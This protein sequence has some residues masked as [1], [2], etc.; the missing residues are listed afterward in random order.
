MPVPD[1]GPP[2]SGRT[3]RL[4]HLFLLV[5]AVTGVA[6]LELFPFSGFRLFSELRPSERQSWQLRAVD[7]EGAEIAIRLTELP[8]GYR[9]S[10]TLLRDFD[11]LTP[12][13]R[14]DICDAWAQPLRDR[15]T[16]VRE[17]RVYAVVQVLRRDAPPPVRTL[18]YECG[19][20][21]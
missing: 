10:S 2:V 3:R 11:A 15:G 16:S 17:V 14:D 6:H 19:G 18:A 8:L 9:N 1:E 4:V 13:E 20:S 5:F 12:D 7:E 21:R